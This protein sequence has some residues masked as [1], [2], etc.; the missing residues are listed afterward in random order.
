MITDIEKLKALAKA[1]TPG[2]WSWDDED[3]GPPDLRRRVTLYAGRVATDS[4]IEGLGPIQTHGMNLFGRM[5]PDA[6]G[7]NNFNYVCAVSPENV[8]EIITELTDLR[9]SHEL[10]VALRNRIDAL[11]SSHEKYTAD[12]EAYNKRRDEEILALRAVMDA[13]QVFECAVDMYTKSGKT[14]GVEIRNVHYTQ[15]KLFEALDR[16]KEVGSR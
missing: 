1:A 8:L 7:T 5:E 10:S 12:M 15:L 9:A 16:A 3:F 13:A 6:N 11:K 2:P 4:G 14:D